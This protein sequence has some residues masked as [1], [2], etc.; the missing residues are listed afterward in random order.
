[1]PIR[2]YL[3]SLLFVFF[4]LHVIAQLPDFGP[5]FLQNEVATVRITIDPD[6]LDA[7]LSSEIAGTDREFP[8]TFKYESSVLTDSVA[9]IGF[10]LRG[11]TSIDA[12]K[13]SFKVSF[14][15]YQSV[16][17]QGLEKLNLNGSANDPSMIRAKLC[18]DIIRDADL[19]G[20]RTSFVKLYING[21]YRGLYSNIEHIDENFAD[22][23]FPQ[24]QY[25]TQFKCLYPATLEYISSN[26]NAYNYIQFDRRPYDQTTN[27][28]TNDYRELAEFISI[29]N[30]TPIL[31]LPCS[32]ERRFD[33]DSY[34]RY[35]ALDVLTGNWDGYIYNKNNFYLQKDYQ[36]GRFHFIPY[37]LD[38]TLGIDWVGQDWT[39]RNV[40]SWAP[41]SE[42]R[43]LFKRLLQVPEYSS[44]YQN[45]IREFAAS[46]FHP[47]SIAAKSASMLALIQDA[48]INDTYRSMDF[49]FTYD[50]FLNSASSA[51]GSHVAYGINDY[52]ALRVASA[53]NQTTASQQVAHL[54]GGWIKVNSSLAYAQLNGQVNGLVQIDVSVLSDMSTI[55][56]SYTLHDDG[57]APDMAAGDGLYS[58]DLPF[59]PFE[60]DQIYY[61]F[62]YQETGS[63]ITQLWPCGSRVFFINASSDQLINEMMS[64]NSSCITD[65][66]GYFSDW[67]ELYNNQTSS[68]SIDGYYLSN[69]RN[70]L[71]KWPMPNVSIPSHGFKLLWANSDEELSRNN[72]NFKLSAAGDTLLLHKKVD[73][74]YQLLDQ[75]IVPALDVNE[76]YGLQT[77]GVNPWMVFAA[78]LTTP[79][80]SNNTSGLDMLA[81][82]EDGWMVYPNPFKD[83]L[84]VLLT[85]EMDA[86]ISL[87]DITGRLINSIQ[88]NKQQQIS[89]QTTS[90]KQ[91]VYFIEVRQDSIPVYRQKLVKS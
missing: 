14:N 83:Q 66:A 84:T 30:Q 12:A 59:P 52:A 8:A 72:V 4:H 64:D 7:L 47:D 50:D 35:A 73:D 90:L 61:R 54:T 78:N 26:P 51:W 39:T 23:Y 21:E 6:S 13:K 65:E 67:I 75:V 20:A 32:L 81:G 31:D 1:M 63:S 80:E 25:S 86:Q 53:L 48:A 70:Y 57:L 77:D 40:M 82:V 79:N 2:F 43:P 17:W 76:S 22:L 33:V 46:V 42:N 85:K 69:K 37:D 27:D 19:P 24:S 38:N 88:V 41:S 62:R 18:W 60:T 91:G 11:N 16:K 10:R 44:R 36:T 3:T 28:Y 58:G 29:L 89:I 68:F 34:L 9:E 56:A 49:G 74:T 45:Y 71:N 55:L 87:Y 5:A 15:T